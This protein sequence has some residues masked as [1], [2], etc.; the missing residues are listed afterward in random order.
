MKNFLN[1]IHIPKTITQIGEANNVLFVSGDGDIVEFVEAN[2]DRNLYFLSGVKT[3]VGKNRACDK[4]VQHRK[5]IVLDLDIR[6]E[7]EKEGLEITDE[8]IKADGL[9]IAKELEDTKE[10]SDWEYVIFSGN[11]IHIYFIGEPVLTDEYYYAGVDAIYRKYD[12]LGYYPADKACKNASRILRVPGSYNNKKGKKKVEILAHKKRDSQLLVLVRQIGEKKLEEAKREAQRREIKVDF[13]YEDRTLDAINK[14]PVGDLVAKHYGWEFDGRNFGGKSKPKACFVP[15]G[16][17]FLV[18]GGTDH[19]SGNVG[20]SCFSF[21]SE[22]HG[23]NS[24]DT[25]KWFCNNFSE[26]D[27]I[28][29]KA[30]KVWAH[31]NRKDHEKIKQ[32]FAKTTEKI[33]KEKSQKINSYTWGTPVLDKN[34]SALKRTQQV[35]IAAGTGTGKTTYCFYIAKKNAELGH[36]VLYLSL[37]MTEWEVQE[38]MARDYAGITIEEDRNETCPEWKQEKFKKKMK[39]LND[40]E[41]LKIIGFPS[42]EARNIEAVLAYTEVL[43]EWDMIIVDN[44]GNM[45]PYAEQRTDTEREGYISE[46]VKNYVKDKKIPI[47]LVHHTNKNSKAEGFSAIRGS[48]K[49]TDN[50][51]DVILLERT[52][53]AESKK[54]RMATTIKLIK[55]RRHNPAFGVIYFDRGKFRDDFIDWEETQPGFMPPED[56][57]K[58]LLNF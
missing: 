8:Q 37:E 6:A 7:Y 54:E 34:F 39:E 5:Y 42:K 11:G 22:V 55:A 56:I 46:A 2:A 10:F 44:L 3:A 57:V 40:L 26:I 25:F 9:Q 50:A 12:S 1:R 28:D 48:G 27:D 17:N 32:H 23:L 4:D 19:L 38:R 49:I 24:A 29:R 47:I 41:R 15:N 16:E 13:G 33:M 36:N 31:E 43:G 18:H 21:I 20:Y 45:V 52:A 58:E 35:V 30:K 14:I 53:N 51:D